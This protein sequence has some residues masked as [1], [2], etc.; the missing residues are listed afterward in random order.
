MQVWLEMC[1]DRLISTLCFRC[2]S[3]VLGLLA[4]IRSH[5]YCQLCVCVSLCV[6]QYLCRWLQ[7][8]CATMYT[9]TLQARVRMFVHVVSL[10][11]AQRCHG[12]IGQKNKKNTK[13]LGKREGAL[14]TTWG[15]LLLGSIPLSWFS[16][17]SCHTY[18]QILLRFLLHLFPAPIH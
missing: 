11:K 4:A 14:S 9:L 3:S 13:R 6:I 8:M 16:L 7:Y 12:N 15:F 10:S 5:Y 18:P 17:I 2:A 1:C